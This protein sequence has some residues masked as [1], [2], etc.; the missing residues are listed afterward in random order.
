M[1]KN[2]NKKNKQ[3]KMNNKFTRKLSNLIIR[4]QKYKNKKIKS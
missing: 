4:I 3:N 2:N 1:L